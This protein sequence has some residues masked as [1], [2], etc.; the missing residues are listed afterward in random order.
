MSEL[1]NQIISYFKNKD[2]P[3]ILDVGCY[4]LEDG[5]EFNKLLPNSTVF[6]FEADPRNRLLIKKDKEVNNNIHL[7]EG[8]IGNSNNEIDFHPS[9]SID[10]TKKW[11]LSGS[12]RAPKEHLKEYTVSF[13]KPFKVQCQTLD[14]WYIN[15][16]VNGQDI[17]L[18]Y[19]DLNG[20]DYDMLEGASIVLSKTHLIYVECFDIELYSGQKMTKDIDELLVSKG[21]KYLIEHGHNR[22][23]G[24][25]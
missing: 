25:D 9:N 1:H 6:G 14:N 11:N 3:I 21:F 16:K 19:S 13:G 23:Y 17:E 2:N 4:L 22:L 7:V 12:I 20:A 24:R 5:K 15:S 10:W 8:A 18:I